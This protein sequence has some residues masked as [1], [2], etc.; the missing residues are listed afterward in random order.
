MTG[1]WAALTELILIISVGPGKAGFPPDPGSTK[2]VNVL[3]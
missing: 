3:T 2:Y 1:F